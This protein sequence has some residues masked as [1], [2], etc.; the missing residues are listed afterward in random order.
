MTCAATFEDAIRCTTDMI[1]LYFQACAKDGTLP[2][3][4]SRLGDGKAMR[5]TAELDAP[6]VPAMVSTQ[7]EVRA[8][9]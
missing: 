4:L 1:E 9:R 3:V 8:S 5:F 6:M 2:A 7:G